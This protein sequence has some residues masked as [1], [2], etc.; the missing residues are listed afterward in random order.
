MALSQAQKSLVL[1][2]RALGSGPERITLDREVCSYLVGVIA[3]DLDLLSEFPEFG[4]CLPAFFSD[5][6]IESLRT[7]GTDFDTVVDRLFA[8]DSDADSYFFCLASI[9]KRRL[10]FARIQNTQR[11]PRVEEVGPRGLLQFGSLSPTALTAL[12]VWRKWLYDIDNRAAQETGYLFEPILAYAI[13]GAPASSRQSPVKRE[14][15]PEKGRQVD[16]IFE[17]SAYEFKIRVTIAASG[18]GRWR[19]ELQFPRDCRLSGYRPVLFVL[20]STPNPKLTELQEA[21]D[22]NGGESKIGEQAWQH[23][24]MQAGP[25]MTQFLRNYVKGPINSLLREAPQ[26]LPSL[27]LSDS[28][29]RIAIAIGDERLVLGGGGTRLD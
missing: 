17:N 19:E 21:F 26:K 14:D 13:G 27:H 12:M 20:D 9:H 5:Q 24:E 22:S 29:G 15:R 23:L 11:L 18:Q 6:P 10:K 7:D 8:L 16:C 4:G 2:A 25:T 28:D 3:S 1:K